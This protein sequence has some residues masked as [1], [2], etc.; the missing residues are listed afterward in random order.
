MALLR[1]GT[2][3][4]R[5][6]TLFLLV[7]FGLSVMLVVLTVSAGLPLSPLFMVVCGV[8]LLL[9]LWLPKRA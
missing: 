5:R 2:W 9:L 3:T 8:L 6:A 4:W 7:A 1:R